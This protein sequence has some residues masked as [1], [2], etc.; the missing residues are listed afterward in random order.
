MMSKVLETAK[1]LA[2]HKPLF[3]SVAAGKTISTFEQAFGSDAS[4]VR[5][6]PNTPASVG[7]GIT[8]MVRN[9]N[10]SA[11][12]AKLASALLSAVGEVVWLDKE[13]ELDA[14]T[15]VSG[16]GPAYVFY[17][18]ECLAA[19]G[20]AAGLE[21]E[22]AMRLARATVAGAGEL[23]RVSGLPAEELRKNVTS[24]QGTT[25]AALRVLM[26]AQGLDPL[27]NQAVAAAARR[28]HE[29]AGS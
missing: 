7:R 11:D 19:A 15:A 23:M 27:V 12:Q 10:V 9:A 21:A 1:T 13:I 5:A 24:P 17:F 2:Q 14:V 4:I 18:T 28:A 6:M 8:A 26:D 3:M 22:L 29:L 16:S 25:E 20:R